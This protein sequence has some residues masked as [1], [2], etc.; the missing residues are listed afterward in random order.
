VLGFFFK[1]R[2]NIFIKYLNINKIFLKSKKFLFF[3]GSGSELGFFGFGFCFFLGF[4]V[5]RLPGI[6]NLIHD[7]FIFQ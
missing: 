4:W 7:N 5:K 3:F 1:I 2:K 6:F